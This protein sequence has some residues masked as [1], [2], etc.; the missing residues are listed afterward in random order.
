[1]KIRLSIAIAVLLSSALTCCEPDNTYVIEGSLYGGRNF[2]GE[3]I[4]LVPLRG[5]ADALVDSAAIHDGRFRFSG[6]VTEPEVC[7]LRMRPMMRLFIEEATLIKEPGRVNVI[8]SAQS[9]VAGTPLNDS[10]QT[11]V[12]F[13]AASDSI[14]LVLKKRLRRA[15]PADSATILNQQDSLKA[16]F[17]DFT[18]GTMKRNQANIFGEYLDLYVR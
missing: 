9:R 2:E 1:M 18:I 4:Q 10:L 16:A 8:L 14:A 12:D 3:Y 13:K 7:T 6:T 17:N 11:W 5:G 15:A